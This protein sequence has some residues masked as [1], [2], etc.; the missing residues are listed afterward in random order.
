[1]SPWQVFVLDLV[2]WMHVVS[3]KFAIQ[4]KLVAAYYLMSL[5]SLIFFL[6]TLGDHPP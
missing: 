6:A 4:S 2:G 5:N 1:M 3:T